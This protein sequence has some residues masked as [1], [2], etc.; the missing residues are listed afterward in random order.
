MRDFDT[1]T[2]NDLDIEVMP[3]GSSEPVLHLPAVAVVL[4]G[5]VLVFPAGPAH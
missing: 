5:V 2:I 4:V 3:G 1:L